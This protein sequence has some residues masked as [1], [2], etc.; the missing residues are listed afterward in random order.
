MVYKP[1]CYYCGKEVKNRGAIFKIRK[2]NGNKRPYIGYI[3]FHDECFRKIDIK[4]FALTLLLEK[5]EILWIGDTVGLQ[6]E[7]EWKQR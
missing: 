4:A 2:D 5:K 1:K 7:R 3:F 6:M